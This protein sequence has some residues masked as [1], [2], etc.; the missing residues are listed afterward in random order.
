MS[1]SAVGGA[2]VLR[3]DPIG[4]RAHGLCAQVLP[5]LVDLDEWGYPVVG[6]EPVPAALLAQ[7]K[8]AAAACPVL[9]LRL[10]RRS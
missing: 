5:E 6:G 1:G 8:R 4:C 9:A 2:V 3:V 7:A 10:S